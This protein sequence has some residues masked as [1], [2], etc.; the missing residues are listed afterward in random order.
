MGA[1]GVFVGSCCSRLE[2]PGERYVSR[3]MEYEFDIGCPRTTAGGLG[4]GSGGGDMDDVSRRLGVIEND[5]SA[6]KAG[7]GTLATQVGGIAARLPH[8]ATKVE[9][10][11]LATQVGGIAAQLPHM[12][13]RVEV[14]ALATQIGAIAAQLPH[15]ATK[16]EV[17]ALATQ[18]GGIAAQLPHMA[19]KADVSDAKVSIIQWMVGTTIAVAGLAFA[20]AKFVH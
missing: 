4:A 8:M 20:V 15:M 9:V 19:S 3:V 7:V 14:E 12:A 16:V 6:T 17:G 5:V 11:A 2:I 10:E 1:I 18:V 13:T